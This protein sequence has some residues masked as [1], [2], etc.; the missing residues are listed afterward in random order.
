MHEKFIA[1]YQLLLSLCHSLLIPCHSLLSPCHSLLSPCHSLLRPC[2][3]LLSPC[4]SLLSLCHSL[5]SPYHPLL[6]QC[7]LQVSL[8]QPLLVRQTHSAFFWYQKNVHILALAIV[9]EQVYLNTSAKNT[10]MSSK[11]VETFDVQKKHVLSLA[12]TLT[13]A[14]TCHYTDMC[15][16]LPLH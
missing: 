9:I 12:T 6:S 15:F 14:F 4:H 8:H 16:H 2:H 13:C 3:S 7:P 11:A 10:K 1:P 5:L